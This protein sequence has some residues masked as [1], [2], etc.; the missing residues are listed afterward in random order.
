MKIHEARNKGEGSFLVFVEG[1]SMYP[2]FEPGSRVPV[3]LMPKGTE[4]EV[5]DII[6]F[7]SFDSY[8][9][10]AVIDSYVYKGKTYYVTGRLNQE[11]NPFVDCTTISS[12]HILGIADLSEEFL[13]GIPAL[14]SQGLLFEM[15]AYGMINQF[16]ALLERAQEIH[17]R[18]ANIDQNNKEAVVDVLLDYMESIIEFKRTNTDHLDIRNQFIQASIEADFLAS[19]LHIVNNIFTGYSSDLFKQMFGRILGNVIDPNNPRA[20]RGDLNEAFDKLKILTEILR[21]SSE[22]YTIDALIRELNKKFLSFRFKHPNTKVDYL[23]EIT[24]EIW[25]KSYN[26]ILVEFLRSN[27]YWT[28]NLLNSLRNLEGI[29]INGRIV[30]FSEERIIGIVDKDDRVIWLELGNE[31]VGLIHIW[32]E[33]MEEQFEDWGIENK[34]ELVNLI[35]W[36]IKNHNPFEINTYNDRHTYEIKYNGINRKITIVISKN[37]FIVSAWPESW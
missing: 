3:K 29:E 22:F 8:I 32:N 31:E 2:L 36:T 9:I 21:C 35:L 33:H 30:S 1:L 37:G 17:E 5:G 13:A 25:G 6:V 26:N 15:K 27:E 10:H 24:N 16:D 11:T 20:I 7:K 23:N 28:E 19:Y 34:K 14:E 4:Y 18:M 12:D